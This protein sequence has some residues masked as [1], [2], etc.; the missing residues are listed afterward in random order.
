MLQQGY[1]VQTYIIVIEFSHLYLTLIYISLS[2]IL[3]KFYC[4]VSF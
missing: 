1:L 2:S 4:Y 3:V